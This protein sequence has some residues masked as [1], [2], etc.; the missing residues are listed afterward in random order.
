MRIEVGYGLEGTLTD[1]VSKLIIENSI[2]PRFKTGDF[3]GGIKRGVE[4][5]IQVLSGDAEEWQRHPGPAAAARSGVAAPR[6][7]GEERRM[8]TES[9]KTR[10]TEAIRNAEW[11]TAGEIFCVV[12]RHASD[13]PLLPIAWAAATALLAPLPLIYLTRWSA[14]TIYLSQLTVFLMAALALS[15]PKLRF[16]IVSRQ[17]KHE[18]AHAEATR[19]FFAQKLHKTEHSDHTARLTTIELNSQL[20]PLER[21]EQHADV[22]I[23]PHR[24]KKARI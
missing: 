13:Y 1:A 5:I 2:L 11:R 24:E 8:I 22:A 7:A 19:Q 15:H 17:A 20:A 14:A 9:D 12:A 6:E 23:S 18:R 4:D 10:I 21:A 16:H 3:S